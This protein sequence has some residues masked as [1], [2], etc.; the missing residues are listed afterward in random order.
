LVGA[1]AAV[2]ARATALVAALEQRVERVARAGRA[3]ARRPRIALLEWLAPPFTAGHWTPELIALAGGV[4]CLGAAG[5][6]SRTASWSEVASADPDRIVVACCGLSLERTA[7]ELAEV[8]RLPGWR[9][10]RAVR[11]G[12]VTLVDGNHYFNR[13]GPRLIDSLELLAHLLAPALHPRPACWDE[14]IEPLG[15]AAVSL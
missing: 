6:R 14:A 15:R 11:N 9:N 12:A 3:A 5:A 1:A 7:A 8:A 13:P 4:P 10:L 2:P